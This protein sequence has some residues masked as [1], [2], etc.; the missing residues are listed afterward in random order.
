MKP[1]LK[2]LDPFNTIISRLGLKSDRFSDEQKKMIEE[3]AISNEKLLAA[4]KMKSNF[5]S[6]IRNANNNPITS[7]LELLP[8]I[9]GGK[10]DQER[11]QKY[12]DL[13]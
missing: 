11:H 2:K 1:S 4:E 5:L 12:A 9:A 8:R 10:V 3:L 6:N 13:I 7:I